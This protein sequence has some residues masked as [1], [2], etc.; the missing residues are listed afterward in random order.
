MFVN[1]ETKKLLVK[2]WSFFRKGA[3]SRDNTVQHT[4]VQ[5]TI[6]HGRNQ[7]GDTPQNQKSGWKDPKNQESGRKNPDKLGFNWQKVRNQE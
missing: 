4:T 1:E 6:P 7:E 5:Q 3:P 2:T